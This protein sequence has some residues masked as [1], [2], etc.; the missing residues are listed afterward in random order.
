MKF[1]IDKE[2][3]KNAPI[4]TVNP[5]IL[6]DL[7]SLMPIRSTKG[8]AGYDIK[9]PVDINFRMAGAN[10]SPAISFDTFI[11][12]EDMPKDMVALVFARSSVGIEKGMLLDNAVAVIDSDYKDTIRIYLHSID[13]RAYT[14]FKAGDRVAQV[15]FVKH[16]LVDDDIEPV[17]VRDGGLGSTGK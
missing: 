3:A 13:A 1:V 14:E 4:G 12:I 7:D 5:K 9:I 16:Y 8:S 11:K 2:K 17:T 10:I 6:N 15:V